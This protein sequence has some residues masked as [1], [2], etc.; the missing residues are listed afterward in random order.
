MRRRITLDED[1]RR[2]GSCW[3]NGVEVELHAKD[4]EQFMAALVDAYAALS[5]R[6]HI[7]MAPE[8]RLAPILGAEGQK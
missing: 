8:A 3:V 2:I 6:E 4:P 7:R 1:G 5:D